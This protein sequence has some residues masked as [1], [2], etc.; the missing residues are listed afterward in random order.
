MDEILFDSNAPLFQQYDHLPDADR[1]QV[2]G[3][4]WAGKF[5][6]DFRTEFLRFQV[7]PDPNVG[8]EQE[9]HLCSKFVS[10]FNGGPW[11]ASPSDSSPVGPTI[12]PR[13]T[14]VPT[15]VPRRGASFAP[16]G[17]TTS[18]TTWPKRVTR[19]G[20]PVLRTRSSTARQVALNLEM[21]IS[22]I[23]SSI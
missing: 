21:A 22:S 7:T 6:N 8:V 19:I 3:M 10:S 12:S 18:A 1:G 5:S 16:P 15:P 17:G 4:V 13:M 23:R 9:S 14:P 20:L 11:A 2:S